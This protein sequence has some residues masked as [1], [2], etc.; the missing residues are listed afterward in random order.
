MMSSPMRMQSQMTPPEEFNEVALRLAKG[1]GKVSE[2]RRG[3]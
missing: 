3:M 1:K 2:V